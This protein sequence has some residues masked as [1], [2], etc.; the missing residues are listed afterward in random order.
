MPTKAGIDAILGA[1]RAS[2]ES[3]FLPPDQAFQLEACADG[4][5]RVRI[6]WVD[7][8]GVLPL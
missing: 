5:D 6:E 3:E 1:K 8:R 4:P 7:P 2:N